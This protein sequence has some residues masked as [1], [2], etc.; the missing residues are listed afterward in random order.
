[1]GDD[2]QRPVSR[3]H[4]KHPNLHSNLRWSPA[5]TNGVPPLEMRFVIKDVSVDG[6]RRV[7]SL[8]TELKRWRAGDRVPVKRVAV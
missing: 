4:Q 1:M 8:G 3:R 7:G 6:S 2:G 5:A